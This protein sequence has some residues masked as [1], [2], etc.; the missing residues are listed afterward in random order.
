MTEAILRPARA[1]DAAPCA[2]IVEAWIEA[3]R[4]MPRVHPPGSIAALFR[5]AI[6]PRSEVTVA[7]VQGE[8]AGFVALDP[9]GYVH[10]LHAAAPGS[11]IGRQ[12]LDAAKAR[13]GSLSLWTFEAN[14]HARRFY[15]RQGFREG[16]RSEGD[17]PEALPDVEYLWR[18]AA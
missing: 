16:R 9:T 10:A 17:N 2:A 15:L 18:A 1:F 14:T 8:V 12:L 7:E 13:A 4:W 6:W 5:Q 11:G 3:S